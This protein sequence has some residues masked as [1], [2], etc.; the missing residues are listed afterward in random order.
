MEVLL[1]VDDT[2]N[3]ET[4]GTGHLA[5]AIARQVESRGWGKRTYITRHQLF[6]HPDVP[7]TSHNSSMCFTAEIG[8]EF[9]EPLISHAAAFLEKE[10]AQG[11]DPG[12]CVA[13]VDRLDGAED[14]V[15]FGRRAKQEV[16]RKA[17]AYELARR[18]GVHLSEHGGTGGGVIGA[19]AGV[20]LRMSGN[21]GRVRGHLEIEN[22]NGVAT[23]RDIRAHPGVGS[24]LT[25]EGQALHDEE[26]VLLSGWKVKAVLQGG[27][28]VL[29]V[30]PSDCGD[31]PWQTC[32]REILKAY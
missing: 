7:Y 11:S 13:V 22:V 32:S 14:L 18:M 10:S 6:V 17:E 19:L 28:P 31:A 30:V 24:V 29:L 20:G 5:E 23:V 8:A 1:A 3:L 9:L 25:L 4:K 27:G 2:D 12:L 21:D 16:V 15:A 26:A